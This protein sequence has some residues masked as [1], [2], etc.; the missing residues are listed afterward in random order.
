MLAVFIEYLAV[1]DGLQ[2]PRLCFEIEVRSF[3]ENTWYKN[4]SQGWGNY[5][6]FTLERRLT[7][8]R[9]ATTIPSD[10]RAPVPKGKPVPDRSGGPAIQGN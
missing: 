2:P 9:G 10:D 6:L 5:T 7:L 1:D 3:F 8:F 4:T